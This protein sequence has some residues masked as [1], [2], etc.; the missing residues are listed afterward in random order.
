MW[1]PW[2]TSRT[3][4]QT[5]PRRSAHQARPN[6]SDPASPLL[7]FDDPEK[8]LVARQFTTQL[9]GDSNY[10]S[11]EERRLFYS[12]NTTAFFPLTEAL[13]QARQVVLKFQVLAGSPKCFNSVGVSKLQAFCT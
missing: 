13:R 8:T 12:V 5:R 9:F 7:N 6:L 10:V 1:S 4:S 3:Q 2:T 11:C